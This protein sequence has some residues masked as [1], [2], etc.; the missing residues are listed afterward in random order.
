MAS[1]LQELAAD[2]REIGRMGGKIQGP[3]DAAAAAAGLLSRS[4]PDARGV[5]GTE[6]LQSC[7]RSASVSAKQAAADIEE[8]SAAA[9]SFA[10]RLAN[11]G[12]ARAAD[13][14]RTAPRSAEVAVA[15]FQVFQL[16]ASLNPA[17]MAARQG[18]SAAGS[19]PATAQQRRSSANANE[20]AEQ[21]A[22]SHG[23]TLDRQK[24]K[25]L[26]KGP[27]YGGHSPPPPK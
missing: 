8:F 27:P 16:M 12:T 1:K 4:V 2:V 18:S 6:A 24:H 17:S 22:D 10:D 21:L 13:S 5:R 25:V 14:K 3:I 23:M 19:T 15:V 7:L 26:K 20:A 9:S 11:D